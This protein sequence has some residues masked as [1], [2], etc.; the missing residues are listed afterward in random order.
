MA[1][2]LELVLANGALRPHPVRDTGPTPE[3]HGLATE[4]QGRH[5]QVHILELPHVSPA[6]SSFQALEARGASLVPPGSSHYKD[7][8]KSVPEAQYVPH[9]SVWEG[10]ET[11]NAHLEISTQN[12]EQ[13]EKETT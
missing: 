8:F 6:S 7:H 12:D 13:R 10:K 4:Q 2:E 9:L 5:R 11:R 1:S 3:G